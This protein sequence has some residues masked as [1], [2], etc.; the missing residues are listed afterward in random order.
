MPVVRIT[1]QKDLKAEAEQRA[2]AAGVPVAI[3]AGQVVEA[4]LV[5]ARCAHRSA[6]PPPLRPAPGEDDS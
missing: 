1:L 4:F 5:D 6:P 2:V 3:W